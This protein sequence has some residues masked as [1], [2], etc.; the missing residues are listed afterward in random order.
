MRGLRDSAPHVPSAD[1]I[2]KQCTIVY[3][4]YKLELSEGGA[5]SVLI[6]TYEHYNNTMT[7]IVAHANA[8][9]NARNAMIMRKCGAH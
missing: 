7:Q 9:R 5:L 8:A 4:A 1:F 3:I 6:L 2:L